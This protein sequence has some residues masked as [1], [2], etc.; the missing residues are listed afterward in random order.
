MPPVVTIYSQEPA[1]V[2]QGPAFLMWNIL[3]PLFAMRPLVSAGTPLS[4]SDPAAPGAW[5][6]DTAVA[7]GTLIID[8]NNNIELALASTGG[9]GATQP[10]WPTQIGAQTTDGGVTWM[11]V[12]PSF[13]WKASTAVQTDQQVRAGSG[14]IWQ[15][16]VAGTTGSTAPTDTGVA[17]GGMLVD[18]TAIWMNLGPTVAMGATTGALNF[19][20]GTK[21]EAIE[22]DQ[23]TAPIDFVTT[24]E[25]AEIDGELYEL[26]PQRLAVAMPNTLFASGTDPLFPTNAQLYE[27]SSFGG[28]IRVPRPCVGVFSYRRQFGSPLNL[29]SQPFKWL[30]GVIYAAGPTSDGKFGISLKKASTYKVSCKGSAVIWRPVGDQIGKVFEQL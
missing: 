11:F 1:F 27:E 23:N 5:A 4:I 8:S 2:H 12:G 21:Q 10:S 25:D 17:S 30:G 3:R 6:A 18:G 15:V 28:Q 29:G 16:I 26:R 9:T 19:S 14:N 22:A 20:A 24:S 7:V 13:V